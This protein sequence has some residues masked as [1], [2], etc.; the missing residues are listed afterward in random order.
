MDNEKKEKEKYNCP[1][2]N[3]SFLT[4]YKL[5]RHLNKKYPCNQDIR[6]CSFCGKIFYDSSTRKR[7]E[8]ISCDKAVNTT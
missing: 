6:Q 3:K 7:H 8:N 1:K 2:C 4:L 5:N